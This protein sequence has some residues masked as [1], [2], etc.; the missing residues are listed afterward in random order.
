MHCRMQFRSFDRWRPRIKCT[1][2]EACFAIEINCKH[3]LCA[4]RARTLKQT[5]KLHRGLT[6]EMRCIKV[7]VI[8]WCAY[9]RATGVPLNGTCKY[10][11]CVCSAYYSTF[12]IYCLLRAA[13]LCTPTYTLCMMNCAPNCACWGKH[14]NG[15]I[16][17]KILHRSE[18][19]A[20]PTG[21]SGGNV[22]EILIVQFMVDWL[23]MVVS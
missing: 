5:H 19:E 2:V 15:V 16:K 14:K 6:Y 8:N 22:G 17:R 4:N 21:E 1:G 7:R 12:T 3:L 10:V 11:V 23:K 20:P 9:T 18:A 13:D